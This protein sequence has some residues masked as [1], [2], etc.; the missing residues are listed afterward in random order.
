MTLRD[1]PIMDTAANNIVL[2]HP[3]IPS[4]AASAVINVLS[5]RWIGQGPL[6]DKFEM[7]WQEK[8]G[9]RTIAVNSGT[10]ALHLAYELAGIEEGDDV[11][12]PLFTCTATNIPLAQMN[13]R[14]RFCDVAHNSLN[15][16]TEQ[17]IDLIT[18]NTK[19]VIV[20][21]YAGQSL[22][23]VKLYNFCKRKNVKLIQDCAHG[24]GME[25]NYRPIY[26]FADYTMFSL[27]AIKTLTVGDGGMLT[28]ND[29]LPAAKLEEARRRRW[30]G[31]D[32]AKKQGGIWENDILELGHKWQMTDISAAIGIEALKSFDEIWSVRNRNMMQY[33]E[34]LSLNDGISNLNMH[35]VDG[36]KHGSWLATIGYKNRFALQSHL[37]SKGIETNQV[38]YR[39]DRY[40]IFKEYCD[41]SVFKNMDSV[42][43]DYLVLPSHHLVTENQ[44]EMICASIND[45]VSKD[46]T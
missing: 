36:D 7:D 29:D 25:H 46:Y 11:L 26:Q 43:N 40:S 37:Y 35:K 12:V 32:R 19:A 34:T 1:M 45:F 18:P 4:T 42:E 27:Q 3:F 13:A 2:F 17:I 8:F 31:I 23:M 22:D 20:V 28:L 39:N 24:I 6:V 30:F 33:S 9:G 41:N 15:T 21:H 38:H 10:S 16:S 44:I 14:L 5:T